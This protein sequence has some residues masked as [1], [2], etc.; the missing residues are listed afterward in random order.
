VPELKFPS[1]I[2]AHGEESDVFAR[3]LHDVHP[4]VRILEPDADLQPD[5]GGLLVFGESVFGAMSESPPPA[6]LAALKADIPVLGVGW[7][8]H[9][10][11]VALG[12]K[13]PVRLVDSIVVGQRPGR[14][15]R[16]LE[17]GKMRTFLTLGGKVAATIGAGGPV[18]TPGPG[19]FAIREAEKASGLMASAYDIETGAIEAI[20]MP[21]YHWIIGVA[22]PLHRLDLLPARFD[23][24][25]ASFVERSTDA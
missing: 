2:T 20:E 11:N 17:L 12:G 10:L 8:M 1:L 3:V 18:A 16:I 24:I 6:L 4:Q 21:G 5:I 19:E 15:G 14:R 13:P 23:N 7:G 22:W 25:V 9:A